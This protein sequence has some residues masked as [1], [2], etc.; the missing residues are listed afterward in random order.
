MKT[1]KGRRFNERVS[2]INELLDINEQFVSGDEDDANTVL[3]VRESINKIPV[4][5]RIEFLI[6]AIKQGCCKTVLFVAANGFDVLGLDA[7]Q[8]SR[9]LLIA[10]QYFCAAEKELR[11]NPGDASKLKA[12]NNA[13]ETFS[14]MFVGCQRSLVEEG[15]YRTYVAETL[16]EENIR[17]VIKIGDGAQEL[18]DI[19]TFKSA[20]SGK[21]IQGPNN[22]IQAIIA[23]SDCEGFRKLLLKYSA[24][25]E[26]LGEEK[27][28]PNRSAS[29][30]FEAGSK[31]VIHN[32][33]NHR[34]AGNQPSQQ[35]MGE[36]T[37]NVDNKGKQGVNSGNNA[38][39]VA[40]AAG[41]GV[42]M[43]A[44]AEAGGRVGRG[45]PLPADV[46]NLQV[47]NDNGCCNI[48]CDVL[49]GCLVY[50][51]CCLEGCIKCTPVCLEAACKVIEHCI[52]S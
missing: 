47:L 1:K 12:K 30:N 21:T 43:I 2:N 23:D 24:N 41:G 22:N 35:S 37:K 17:K 10:F 36:E 11:D 9:P 20:V 4:E 39:P 44:A 50:A 3:L 45:A 52:I 34:K 40:L 15:A 25:T 29:Q 28:R 13:R 14:A 32:L 6:E 27:I 26:A 19:G 8:E 49:Q 46:P 38:V 33:Q 7:P 31:E 51:K 48:P 5:Q 16:S 42:V 18:K